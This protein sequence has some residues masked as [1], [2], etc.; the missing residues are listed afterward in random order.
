MIKKFFEAYFAF[1][2]QQRNGL[3]VLASISFLLLI[4][5]MVFPYFIHPDQIEIKNLPLLPIEKNGMDSTTQNA[6]VYSKNFKSSSLDSNHVSIDKPLF[7][8]NPNTVTY[9]Q[10]LLLGFKQKTANTF[11]KFRSKGFHFNQKED[12]KKVYGVDEAL[13]KACK[14]A[15]PML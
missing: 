11:I 1:N 10:L 15:K 8:F 9:E 2:K 6:E 12:L 14:S 5:R 3:L 13:Y 7:E 4:I